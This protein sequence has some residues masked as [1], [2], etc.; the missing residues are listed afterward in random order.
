MALEDLTGSSKYIDDLVNS[1]PVGA[2]DPKSEGDDHIRGIKNVLL[3]SFP[4]ITGAVTATQDE[5]NK[6]DGP[7][8]GTSSASKAAVLGANKDLDELR[9]TSLKD[10]NGYEYIPTGT[11][12]VFFQAAAPNAGWLID[13]THNNKMLRVVSASGGGSGGS[14][15]PILMDKVPAHTHGASSND[16]GGHTHDVYALTGP[17][18]SNAIDEID[19]TASRVDVGSCMQSAGEHSHTIT[20]NNNS[21]G[22]AVNWE[23]YYIDVI[24]CTKQ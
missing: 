16:A 13:A 7:V 12:M 6:L 21:G 10:G 5:L 4:A 20:V 8:A 18:G 17:G 11:K 15:S 23:P 2:S 14:H 19:A 22:N 9:V 24:V 1:N 3:N